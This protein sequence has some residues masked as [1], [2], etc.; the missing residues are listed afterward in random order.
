MEQQYTFCSTSLRL[1]KA[2][3]DHPP[4]IGTQS[5]T[6]WVY[7]D[8][9]PGAHLP[10]FFFTAVYM[11]TSHAVQNRTWNNLTPSQTCTAPMVEIKRF[12]V[13]G[14]EGER[15]RSPFTTRYHRPTDERTL[16]ST[17]AINRV[18]RTSPPCER[19]SRGRARGSMKSS[20]HSIPGRLRR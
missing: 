6:T 11:S 10:I 14:K 9:T 4:G 1:C 20:H 2:R 15:K 19:L 18:V 17:V 16:A 12:M 13:Q 8:H 7:M 3:F 5:C